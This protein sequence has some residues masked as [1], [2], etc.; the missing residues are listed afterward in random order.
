MSQAFGCLALAR[1][2]EQGRGVAADPRRAASL[3]GRACA[4]DALTCRRRGAR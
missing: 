1:M 4:M 2:F 3:R